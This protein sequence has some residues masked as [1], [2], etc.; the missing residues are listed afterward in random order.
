MT[1][2][3]VVDADADAD[4][5]AGCAAQRPAETIRTARQAERAKSMKTL[6]PEDE[7]GNTGA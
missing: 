3:N 5:D 2:I 7:G 4:A 6:Q 1:G